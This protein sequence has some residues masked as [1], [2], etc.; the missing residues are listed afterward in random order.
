MLSSLQPGLRSNIGG[1]WNRVVNT[2]NASVISK[3]STEYAD[4]Y[5]LSESSLF[6]WEDGILMIT[7]GQTILINALPEILNIVDKNNIAFV[8]YERKNFM[9]PHEQPSDFEDDAARMLEL[10]PGKSYRLGPANYDHLH[11]FCWAKAGAVPEPDAILRVLMNNLDPSVMEIFYEKNAGTPALA[12][13]RSGLCDICSLLPGIGNEKK[14]E[15]IMDDYLFSPYGYSLNGI[16]GTNYCTVHVTPQPGSSYASFETNIIK[17][18]YSGV[19]KEI[20]SVFQPGKFSI[21]LTTSV[22]DH[23]LSLHPTVA[24]ALPDYSVTEKS[25]YELDCGYA[26]TFLNYKISAVES[27]K[28]KV[29]GRTGFATPSEM[30]ANQSC[31]R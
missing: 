7:C 19:I 11:I 6:V 16:F 14:T 25:L 18:D 29:Q 13:E 8:F 15:M 17:E 21:A 24:R 30:L 12:G 28:Q 2:S 5:L 27:E 31:Q 9:F 1:R 4:A 10:F 22:E 3:I 20:I 23:F 26:V